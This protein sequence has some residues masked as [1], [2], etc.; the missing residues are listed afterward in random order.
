MSPQDGIARSAAIAM[1][2]SPASLRSLRLGTKRSEG[3]AAV[4]AVSGV[5]GMFHCRTRT[6]SVWAVIEKR[7]FPEAGRADTIWL[8]YH[9]VAHVDGFAGH[10]ALDVLHVIGLPSSDRVRAGA[11][12]SKLGGVVRAARDGSQTFSDS[13]E[14]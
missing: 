13:S 5:W 7:R 3:A 12:R 10:F 6:G 1:T 9:L 2:P 4:M 8:L 11:V 14:Q